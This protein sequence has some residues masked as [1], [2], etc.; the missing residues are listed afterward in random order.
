MKIKVKENRAK[1]FQDVGVG[2]EKWEISVT[3]GSCWW[4]M[5]SVWVGRT[6]CPVCGHPGKGHT[7]A[8][9]LQ[10]QMQVKALPP[11]GYLHIS[12]PDLFSIPSHAACYFLLKNI[13]TLCLCCQPICFIHALMVVYQWINSAF[14]EDAV[15]NKLPFVFS[16]TKLPWLWACYTSGSE[17]GVNDAT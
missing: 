6:G 5:S 10:K 8:S 1:S 11:Q 15:F 17:T 3:H 9:N 13:F 12:L 16:R 14:K 4:W 2:G 7:R